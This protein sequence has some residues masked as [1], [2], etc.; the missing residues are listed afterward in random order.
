MVIES[1]DTKLLQKLTKDKA[2]ILELIPLYVKD[3]KLY[4][5]MC[6][7]KKENITYLKFLYGYPVIPIIVKKEVIKEAIKKFF[8]NVDESKNLNLLFS[9]KKSEKTEEINLNSP[10]S[11]IVNTYLNEAIELNASDIHL[12]PFK[13]RVTIRYRIDGEL[14]IMRNI[15]HEV[16]EVLVGRIKVWANIDIIDKRLPLDGKISYSFEGKNFDIR[17]A[18]MPSVYGEKIVLRL[19]YRNDELINLENLGY[20]LSDISEI[21]HMLTA[22]N[23]I[24]LICGPT[25]SGKSTSLYSFLKELDSKTKNIVTIEDPVEYNIDGITQIN[26]SNKINLT[27]PRCLRSILRSDPDVIMIG[28]IRDEETAEIAVKAAITGH[29]VLSTLHTNDSI[30]SISRLYNMGIQKYLIADAVVGVIS[31]RLI[32]KKCPS[33]GGT[34]CEKCSHTGYKGRICCYEYFVTDEALKEMIN[35]N[36]TQ[37]EIKRYLLSK[38]FKTIEERAKEL[39]ESGVTTYEEYR[40]MCF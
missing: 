39:Y 9:S 36:K 1:I 26:I 19:L 3:N 40:R 35:E 38:N 33:C 21:K 37:A 22:N 34:G 8:K 7:A 24:I 20:A 2:E 27:F 4:T 31:Q 15:P 23:G 17:V 29:L 10:A 32:R 14:V 18:T 16:Y 13:D 30:T 28:E 12:E 5:A 6:E 11:E 25:G